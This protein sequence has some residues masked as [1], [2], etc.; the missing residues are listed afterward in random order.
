LKIPAV[1]VRN[2]TT[3][4]LFQA[5]TTA[6]KSTHRYT[7]VN[8]WTLESGGE[9]RSSA[10]GFQTEGVPTDNSIWFFYLD[11]YI[12]PYQM[13]APR[14]ARFYQLSAYLGAGYK[15]EDITTAIETAWK[16]LGVTNPPEMKYHKDTKVLIAVGEADKLK[17]IDDA[18]KQLSTEKPKEKSNDKGLSK[19]ERQ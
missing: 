19:S 10:Y 4:Q 15:V 6:S 16:M 7:I 1:I 18:L 14:T 12:G 11:K 9:E 5:L 2:V 3:E 8:P 17:M 13:I